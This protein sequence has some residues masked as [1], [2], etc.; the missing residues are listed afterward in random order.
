[1]ICTQRIESGVDYMK[2]R[3]I[4]RTATMITAAALWFG[5]TLSQGNAPAGIGASSVSASVLTEG[6]GPYAP[7][8]AL[9]KFPWDS[10]SVEF[11]RV[12]FVD[13]QIR[14][15][16][17]AVMVQ[18]A[19][20]IP[21]NPLL[22]GMGYRVV[23]NPVEQQLTATRHMGPTL[24]FKAGH[25]T[26]EADGQPFTLRVAP[27]VNREGMIWI[28]LRPA[29]E[30]AGLEVRWNPQNRSVTVRDPHALPMFR[31]ST[32]IDVEPAGP[33]DQILRYMTQE[34]NANVNLELIPARYYNDKI[35][36]MIAAGEPMDLMLLGRP[37]QYDD[38]LFQAI[39]SDL[40]DVLESFPRLKALAESADR[41]NRSVDGR[42]YGIPRPGHPNEAVFPFVQHEWLEKL[43]LANPRTMDEVY[44]VL[45]WFVKHD[46]DGDREANTIGLTGRLLGD[47]VGGIGWVEQAFTGTPTR[48]VHENGELRDTVVGEEERQALKWLAQ[49]YASGLIDDPFFMTDDESI[50]LQLEQGKAGMVGMT[51]IQAASLS[52][53]GASSDHQ[54]WVP[55]TGLLTPSGEPFVPLNPIGNGLYIIPRTV[56]HDK[57]LT[58]LEW[59]DRG[60]A[61][62]ES[63]EWE[64]LS[65][66]D[67]SDRSAIVNV[68]GNRELLPG[69]STVFELPEPIRHRYEEAVSSW[70]S[71]AN[72]NQMLPSASELI[73][74]KSEYIEWNQQ[75]EEWKRQVVLGEQ[76]LDD[77][78]RHI[79]S[80]AQSDTYR[81]MMQ[82]LS[83]LVKR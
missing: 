6:A 52:Q 8:E 11:I 16:A 76:S 22:E 29:A 72:E 66:L 83:E 1:M 5:A 58:I 65:G 59:L 73:L 28:P 80:M 24:T 75:L 19:T 56:P 21:A 31:L 79:E 45:E 25:S 49:A 46:P 30:A 71:L 39:A 78:D 68:F 54:S 69:I 44:T 7:I 41:S 48:F 47:A 38:E 15:P 3:K 9:T 53:T 50:R 18:G 61:M 10:Q 2:R 36:V 74:R 77:W 33:A 14:L 4:Q 51:L 17:P 13:M 81:A 67:R 55:L 12:D 42:I 43:G 57:M 62:T 26:A 32:R 23:W 82:Q 37:Y 63:N 27:Y 64:T 35:N 20:M 40:T 34:M 70:Q 60:L